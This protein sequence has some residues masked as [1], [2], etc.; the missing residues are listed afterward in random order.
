M[1]QKLLG[2]TVGLC[3]PHGVNPPAPPHQQV[4]NTRSA[5]G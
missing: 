3:A 5:Q 1:L 2:G 4:Q